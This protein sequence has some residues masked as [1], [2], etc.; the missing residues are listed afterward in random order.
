[1][2]FHVHVHVVDCCRV[3]GYIG[4]KAEDRWSPCCCDLEEQRI[5]LYVL[6][7]R[8]QSA[9]LAMAL[10]DPYLVILRACRLLLRA[11]GIGTVDNNAFV[12]VLYDHPLETS[13][14]TVVPDRYHIST[15]V[16]IHWR[17]SELSR[18]QVCFLVSTVIVH[19]SVHGLIEL[20]N[21]G[22]AYGG[23]IILPTLL[24][25]QIRL[26]RVLEHVLTNPRRE[27]IRISSYMSRLLSD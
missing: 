27:I 18:W 9:R 25:V 15:S 4:G 1:M 12:L 6:G 7:L 2:T 10:C 23:I 8:T 16:E 3:P 20:R 19:I 26:V 13:V 17:Y 22:R 21:H 5:L 14:N 24:S 11:T